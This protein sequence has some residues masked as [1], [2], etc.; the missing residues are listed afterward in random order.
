MV[1]ILTRGDHSLSIE[2]QM[3]CTIVRY[4]NSNLRMRYCYYESSEY[5]KD[6]TVVKTL[7]CFK[8]QRETEQTKTL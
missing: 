3:N 6:A 2:Y 8:E 1:F 7:D 4:R 5:T